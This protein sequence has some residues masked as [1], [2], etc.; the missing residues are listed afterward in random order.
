MVR[1]VGQRLQV[2]RQDAVAPWPRHNLEF[3][4]CA[5][6][7]APV[8][9]AP[10]D[11][12]AVTAPLGVLSKEEVLADAAVRKVTPYNINH[13]RSQFIGNFARSHGVTTL[14]D[15]PCGD[16]NWQHT[17][18]GVL[19]GTLNYVGG[20]ISITALTKA[21]ENNAAHKHMTFMDHSFDL[22][23]NVPAIKDPEHTMFMVK[24]VLQVTHI[25]MSIDTTSMSIID[26]D[27]WSIRSG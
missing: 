27:A 14:W 4:C 23:E 1:R 16:A 19:N 12:E 5:P 17:I 8:T 25:S 15:I 24:E 13:H 7:P 11:R 10:K 6:S 9:P 2:G 18:P 22:V 20:D 3:L 21:R 26:D